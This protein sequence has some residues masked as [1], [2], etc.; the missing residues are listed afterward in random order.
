MISH[1]PHIAEHL[2]YHSSIR[3]WP[4]DERPREKLLKRGREALS[5]AELLAILIGSGTGRITALDLGKTLL[6]DFGSLGSLAARP[7]QELRRYKGLGEARSVS[8][9]AAFELGRRTAAESAPG[10]HRIGGPDDVVRH[11]GPLLRDLQQEVFRVLLLDS[12][13]H[14]VRDVVISTG[15]L[16][17]SLVHPREVFRPAILEPAAGIILLHNHP[18]GNPE[19]S[20]EDQQVTR[21]LAETGKIMGIPVHDHI[22]VAREKYCSFAERG[23]L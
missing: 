8:L 23:I 3:S 5:D 20:P 14:L 16:N 7:A 6:R 13:N 21:Q 11:Y 22:I 4:I 2:R 12:A 17:C 9:I 19:P 15:I 18:S 10:R 1:D